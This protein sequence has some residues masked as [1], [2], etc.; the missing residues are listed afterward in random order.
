MKGLF[1]RKLAQLRLANFLGACLVLFLP[2]CTDGSDLVPDYLFPE[3]PTT[4]T[5]VVIQFDLQSGPLAGL[6]PTRAV[7][8][9]P[10]F[11][12]TATPTPAATL[13]PLPSPTAVSLTTPASLPSTA[14]DD[15]IPPASSSSIGQPAQTPI[16]A[17]PSRGAIYNGPL[18]AQLA[19]LDPQPGFN[20]P[21]KLNQLEFKWQWHGPE[22]RPCHLDDNFGFELRLWPDLS[23]PYLPAAQR[24]N[25]QPLGAFDALAEQA[26]I[27]D[28]CD[29][30]TGTRR[31]LLTNLNSAPGVA[32]AGGA[33]QFLWD[34]AYVQLK[35]YY[36]VLAVSVPNDFFIPVTTPPVPTVTPTSLYILTPAPK[37]AG[38]IILLKPEHGSVFPVNAGP[39]EFVWQWESQNQAPCGLTAA[40]YGFELHLWSTQPG[41]V[42]LGVMDVVADQRLILCDPADGTYH[43]HLPDLKLAPGIK[44]TYVGELRWDGQF[45]WNVA[46]VSL[47]PYLPPES[48]SP[49]AQFEISLSS[50]SGAID[51]LGRELRCSEIPSWPEAQAIFLAAGSEQD[52]SG[53]DPD[54]NKIA[55]DELRR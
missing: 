20:L 19:L 8:E 44:A 23:N 39:V 46:L 47:S 34:V 6:T 31:Y 21:A 16:P 24:G 29:P 26:K 3:R 15:L 28:S 48:A 50:Y 17:Q 53:L 41:F 22:V 30:E 45:Q 55:C 7:V 10:L 4:A 27:T 49:P 54:G 42:P 38:R 32:L 2:A 1:D 25:I 14:A 36:T 43:Y 9:L 11:P 33:G 52:P 18:S 13:T 40:G 51:R 35:P 12:V 37:P 5:M